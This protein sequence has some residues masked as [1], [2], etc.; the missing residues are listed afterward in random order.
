VVSSAAR[1]SNTDAAEGFMDTF[2]TEAAGCGECTQTDEDG[3]TTTYRFEPLSFPELGDETFATRLTAESP[4][5]P[6]ALDLAF[7]RVDEATVGVVNGG[8]GAADTALT[9][10]LLRTMTDR[11]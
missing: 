5:G 9:E 3:T 6:L 11:L 8:F 7:A 4:L 2:A 10:Q 1:H